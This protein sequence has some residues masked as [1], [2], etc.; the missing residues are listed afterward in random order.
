MVH[1]IHAQKRF[2]AL[3]IV[4]DVTQS[5]FAN[6][7]NNSLLT[8]GPKSKPSNK[9]DTKVTGRNVHIVYKITEY[10]RCWRNMAAEWIPFNLN[11]E[12]YTQITDTKKAHWGAWYE[13]E[14]I[15]RPIECRHCSVSSFIKPSSISFVQNHST[16]WELCMQYDIVVY[17][18]TA[19]TRA[20][21]SI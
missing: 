11:V 9:M 2:E 8:I 16:W 3:P 21:L 19:W 14:N 13:C 18:Y 12:I 1:S 7:I 10:S 5:I 6:E 20:L 4:H 15:F 17:E